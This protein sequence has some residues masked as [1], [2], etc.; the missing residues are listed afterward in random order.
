MGRPPLDRVT[1]RVNLKV[2]Q[3]DH[4]RWVAQSEREGMTLSEWIRAAADLAI[5]RGSTR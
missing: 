5:A 4:A 1:V 2:G 3:S